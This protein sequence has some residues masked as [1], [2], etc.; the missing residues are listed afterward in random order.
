MIQMSDKKPE[1]TRAYVDYL[2]K[3]EYR[4]QKP[5]YTE[6]IKKLSATMK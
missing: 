5:G 1:S 2:I 3:E 6:K 4:S